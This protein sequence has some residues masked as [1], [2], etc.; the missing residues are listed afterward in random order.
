MILAVDSSALALLINPAANPPD[1]PKTGAPVDRARERVEHFIA[2]LSSTDSM[3]IPT[4]VLAEVLVR[5]DEGGPGLLAALG[6]LAR[7]KVR[8]FGERAAV[9]TAH[10]TREAIFLG[11]KKGG[12]TEAWQK[13]KVDR[14][15]IAVARVEGATRIYADDHGLIS[16]AQRLG[17]DVIST[18]DLPYPP[19]Q[20]RTLFSE[21]QP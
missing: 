2:E 13:V 6:G 8:P 1:D 16:F 18:W 12:S 5:A 21:E 14:Q 19:P 9:E 20:Q 17:M 11:D 4:P 15:V 7:M 10:M 3:I